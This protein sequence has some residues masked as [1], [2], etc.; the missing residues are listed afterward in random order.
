MNKQILKK[1]TIIFSII[2]L[3]NINIG[4]AAEPFIRTYDILQDNEIS[5]NKSQINI[6]QKSNYISYNDTL[7]LT[8]T[9]TNELVA[10]TS[11][12]DTDKFDLIN[13]TSCFIIYG[14]SLGIDLNK[15]EYS[16]K[17]KIQ[18]RYWVESSQLVYLDI[19]NNRIVFK[20]DI[21]TFAPNTIKFN[22]WRVKK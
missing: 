17:V 20:A 3:Y 11:I 19:A 16:Y 1:I 7:F 6:I 14:D 21:N 5:Q 2:F 12:T 13:D 9:N 10:D 4:N 18:N 15:Y 22:F 8:L